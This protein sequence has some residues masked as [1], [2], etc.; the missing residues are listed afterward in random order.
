MERGRNVY[1]DIPGFVCQYSLKTEYA[2]N[3][4]I[5]PIG[6]SSS[7]LSVVFIIIVFLVRKLAFPSA[8]T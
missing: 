2:H 7:L 4:S 5:I 6:T 1:N 8:L 3:H